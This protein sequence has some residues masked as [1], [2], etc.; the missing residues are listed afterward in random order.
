M[1][2][3]E[4]NI[5]TK[6]ATEGLYGVVAS[7]ND[8]INGTPLNTLEKTLISDPYIY[9]SCLDYAWNVENINTS[10]VSG[11][12]QAVM[13]RL[14]TLVREFYEEL[15]A[16]VLTSRGITLPSDPT[17]K[18]EIQQMVLD[19][20]IA[21]SVPISVGD[22]VQPIMDIYNLVLEEGPIRFFINKYINKTNSEVD[23]STVTASIMDS[24]VA[25]IKSMNLNI[26]AAADMQDA[27]DNEN[28]DEYFACLLYTS[29]SP[30]DS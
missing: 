7:L 14:S 11:A 24:M 17:L 30:R 21:A 10:D 29:P 19:L 26:P 23:A 5:R 27:I 2:T 4:E 12:Y 6:I 20:V 13:R 1:A 3:I 9:A 25:Y 8:Q 15:I 22:A 16:E 18:E 28:F